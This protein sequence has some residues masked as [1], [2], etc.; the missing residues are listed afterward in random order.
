MVDIKNGSLNTM[1]KEKTM[2]AGEVYTGILSG[3][4]HKL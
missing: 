4:A 2:L 3:E 1:S